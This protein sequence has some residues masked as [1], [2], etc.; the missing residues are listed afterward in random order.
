MIQYWAKSGLEVSVFNQLNG[1]PIL[2]RKDTVCI[3]LAHKGDGRFLHASLLHLNQNLSNCFMEEVLVRLI[4]YELFS[5]ECVALESSN[6]NRKHE[7]LDI[8]SIERGAVGAGKDAIVQYLQ[9]WQKENM[10]VWLGEGRV[11]FPFDSLRY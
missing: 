8:Q 5:S 11:H 6:A 2:E 7:Y 3:L 10:C 4:Y 9:A 1:D